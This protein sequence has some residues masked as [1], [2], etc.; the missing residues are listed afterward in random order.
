M[1]L[2]QYLEKDLGGVTTNLTSRNGKV[3][4]RK[5]SGQYQKEKT[6]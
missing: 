4:L 3:E 1:I 5:E 2:K 6:N